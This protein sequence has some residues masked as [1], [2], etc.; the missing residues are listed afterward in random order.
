MGSKTKN[1]KYLKPKSNTSLNLNWNHL[2]Y[3]IFIIST[4]FFI[5]QRYM[6][7]QW[8]FLVYVSNAKYLFDGGTYFE[9]CRS[10]MISVIMY[11]LSFVG[12]TL[13]E[14]FYLIFVSILFFVAT[15]KFAEKWNLDKNLFY[16]LSM[17][18]F[19]LFFGAS[20]GT[21][22]LSVSFL[23]LF[24]AYIETILA[25]GF[26]ALA[27]LSRYTVITL[28]PFLLLQR[29][30]KKI[31]LSSLLFLLI[32]SPWFLYN[33]YMTGNPLM[34]VIDSYSL[35]VKYRLEYMMHPQNINHFV[36][37]VGLLAPLFI[38]GL[39]KSFRSLISKASS[40]KDII[41][42]G[43]KNVYYRDAVMFIFF[44][45]TVYYYL[46]TPFKVER[47]LFNLIIPVTYFSVRYLSSFDS[48]KIKL[49]LYPIVT[50]NLIVALLILFVT[51]P[52]T[53]Q[54]L[55]DD[56]LDIKDCRLISN[57]WA[58]LNYRD[59]VSEPAPNPT[60][61]LENIDNGYMFLYFKSIG[62][63]EYM[64]DSNYTK[65]LPIIREADKYIIF[66]TGVCLNRLDKYEHLYLRSIG[67]L[68]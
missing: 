1:Q 48:N 20:N 34:S 55:S 58:P 52:Y 3:L 16:P 59:F 56:Y 22:I 30:I 13:S 28:V 7:P 17:S 36:Q 43:L 41:V 63:P 42:S 49:F 18:F 68:P 47:Y 54:F 10:P 8:D 35:N 67:V 24:F 26:I 11:L 19:V 64:L 51:I 33:F 45:M 15:G 37:V 32:L 6:G 53:T 66:G 31:F 38:M 46:G 21:E 40:F 5:I 14:Y 25:G 23:L 4:L 57:A 44:I 29:N 60:K 65:Q 61:L 12:W 50:L 2:S 9:W 27:F 62:E 39:Y